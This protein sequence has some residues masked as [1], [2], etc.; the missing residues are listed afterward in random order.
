M[1][2]QGRPGA[3]GRQQGR[4]EQPREDAVHRD[5]SMGCV[6]MGKVQSIECFR[7]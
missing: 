4:T 3:G 7:S 1:H 2:V 6:S 5:E